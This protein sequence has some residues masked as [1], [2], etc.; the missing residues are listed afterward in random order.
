MGYVF[1]GESWE[2]RGRG[3]GRAPVNYLPGHKWSRKKN[4]NGCKIHNINSV[5]NLL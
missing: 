1:V 5:K 4:P 3:G 2:L